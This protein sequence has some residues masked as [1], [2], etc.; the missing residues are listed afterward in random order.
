MVDCKKKKKK[1]RK[2]WQHQRFQRSQWISC[3]LSTAMEHLKT[4]IINSR[5]PPLIWRY[6]T[7]RGGG[8]RYFDDIWMRPNSTKNVLYPNFKLRFIA[9]EIWKW[10]N[11]VIFWWIKIKWTAAN[12]AEAWKHSMRYNIASILT[13]L[14]WKLVHNALEY[15][16]FQSLGWKLSQ[17]AFRSLI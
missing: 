12:I 14:W 17:V 4:A 7:N 3:V 16:N 8:R 6:S 11:L 2:W 10:K 5:R 9:A 15:F 1:K 13:P